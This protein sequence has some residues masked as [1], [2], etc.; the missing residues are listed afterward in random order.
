MGLARIL[1]FICVKWVTGFFK[2]NSGD[3][4]IRYNKKDE[5]ILRGGRDEH[6]TLNVRG[7]EYK[8]PT[9]SKAK[10]KTVEQNLSRGISLCFQANF[11]LIIVFIFVLQ[12]P[13]YQPLFHDS[14]VPEN[15]IVS[16][17]TFWSS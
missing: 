13:V 4:R 16:F 10:A 5:R 6:D 1:C 3:T 2:Y 8:F 15:W 17:D 11:F 9:D 12:Q 14:S 7:D